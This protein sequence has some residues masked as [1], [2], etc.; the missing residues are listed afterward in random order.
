MK[1][2]PKHSLHTA[3]LHGKMY[4]FTSDDKNYHVA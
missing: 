2:K 3:K 1:K 4:H